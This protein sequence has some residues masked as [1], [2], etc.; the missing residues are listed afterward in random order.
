MTAT[1]ES[2]KRAIHDAVMQSEG[3]DAYTGLPLRW[4]LIS[5]YNNDATTA[6]RREY[7]SKF[8]DLPTVDHVGNGVGPPDFRICAWRTNDAKNDL[9]HEDFVALCRA[10]LDHY[11]RR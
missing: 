1:V 6:G 11:D 2:Y 8:A 7:K 3:L 10:V 9:S 5:K 4:E